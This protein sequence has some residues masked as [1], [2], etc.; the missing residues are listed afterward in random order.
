MKLVDLLRVIPDDY[1]IALLNHDDTRNG[2]M[3]TKNEAIEEFARQKRLVKEQ[4]VNNSDVFKVYPCSYVQCDGAYAFG[5]N[6]IP[7]NVSGMII[8]EIA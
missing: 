3:G 6:D 1:K 7:L 2:G 8:I 4:V 5:D